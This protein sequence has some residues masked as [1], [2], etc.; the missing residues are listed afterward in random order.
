MQ[1]LDARDLF[2]PEFSL[3][4][5]QFLKSVPDNESAHVVTLEKRA[6]MRMKHICSAYN[7]TLEAKQEG[8]TFHFLVKKLAS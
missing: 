2:C 8:D 6:A 5:R 1:Q 3:P 4:V 7:W